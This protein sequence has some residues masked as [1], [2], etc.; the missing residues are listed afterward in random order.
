MNRIQGYVTYRVEKAEYLVARWYGIHIYCW[1]NAFPSEGV[2]RAEQAA[3]SAV[4]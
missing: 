2:A 3:G 1:R 4:V